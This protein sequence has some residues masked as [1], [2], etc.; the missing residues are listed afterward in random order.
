MLQR[1]LCRSGLGGS[2][3][4]HDR[5]CRNVARGIRFPTPQRFGVEDLRLQGTDQ[6]TTVDALGG[7][8]A[9]METSRNCASSTRLAAILPNKA[10]ARISL[11]ALDSEPWAAM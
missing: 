11:G 3:S 7:D 10:A 8:K 1:A 6:I 4:A 2:E 9:S 5:A